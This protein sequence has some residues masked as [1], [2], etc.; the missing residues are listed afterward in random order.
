MNIHTARGVTTSH[1][2]FPHCGNV[3]YGHQNILPGYSIPYDNRVSSILD[4]IHVGSILM[5][6]PS[7]MRKFPVLY[8]KYM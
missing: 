2:H 7:V 3:C 6:N 4:A 1:L 5:N 8:H